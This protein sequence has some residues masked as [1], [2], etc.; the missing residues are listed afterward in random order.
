MAMPGLDW[1]TAEVRGGKLTV[2]I[3]GDPPKGWKDAF[4]STAALLGGGDVG[5]VELQKGTAH[6]DGVAPGS[7]ER[8]RHLLESVVQQAN[9]ALADDEDAEQGESEV[10]NDGASPDAE[11]TQRFRSFAAGD[12]QEQ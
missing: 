7:E 12:E 9:S 11:M 10:D 3:A 2:K 6:V 4:N 1:S 5:R 8:T